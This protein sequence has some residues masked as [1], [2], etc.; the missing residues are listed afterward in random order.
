MLTF[1]F[2]VNVGAFFGLATTYAEKDVGYW[3]A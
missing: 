2:L 1:Y 3:L